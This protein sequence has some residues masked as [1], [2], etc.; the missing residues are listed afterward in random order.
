MIEARPE[1]DADDFLK[2]ARADRDRRRE[3]RRLAAS[4]AL[5]TLHRA[6]DAFRDSADNP[7]AADRDGDR[8]ELLADRLIDWGAALERDL[9]RLELACD[10]AFY[11][12][13]VLARQQ[14]P[15]DAATLAQAFA[16]SLCEAVLSAHASAVL[17]AAVKRAAA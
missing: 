2:A 7:D 4:E 17:L 1:L 13:S 3:Q 16:E 9:G 15:L 8:L 5:A 14:A 12:G 6:R 10:R 11:R